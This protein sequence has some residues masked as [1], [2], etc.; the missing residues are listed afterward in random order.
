MSK[1]IQ[2]LVIVY[3]LIAV[4]FLSVIPANV[5]AYSEIVEVR[6]PTE[7]HQDS[8]GKYIEVDVCNYD[9]YDENYDIKVFLKYPDGEIV[10]DDEGYNI[11]VGER[12]GLTVPARTKLTDQIYIYISP[13]VPIGQYCFYVVLYPAGTAIIEDTLTTNAF[14]LLEK[15]EHKYTYTSPSPDYT[16]ICTICGVGIIIIVI[17]FVV[18]LWHTKSP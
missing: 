1:K 14:T 4:F 9:Y 16:L 3:I 5:S 17:I 8:T 12:K 10:K 13:D 2:P 6:Y 18:A 7:V 15:Q 11:V